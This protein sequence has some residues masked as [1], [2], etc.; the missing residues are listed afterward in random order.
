MGKVY[1]KRVREKFPCSQMNGKLC[2]FRSDSI[3]FGDRCTKPEWLSCYGDYA[4][5][6]FRLATKREI[7][8]WERRQQ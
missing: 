5:T 3:P 4:D 8:A 6:C 7:A 1:L 2:Y